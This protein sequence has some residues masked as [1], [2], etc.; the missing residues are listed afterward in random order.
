MDTVINN[1]IT[2]ALEVQKNSYSPYSNFCVGAALLCQNG[3]V[4]TGCNIESVSFTP[5]ICAERTAIAKAVSENVRDFKM[6][7]IVGKKRNGRKED[8]D[9]ISPC[10]VC[11]QM[12]AEFCDKDFKVIL[13][14][15]VDDYK[16]YTLEQ[17]LPCS[18]SK[19][20]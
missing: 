6:I 17:L 14:K 19:I 1:L 4:F 20:E 18:F 13:A 9:Y 3:K 11:R 10:G 7:A 5:T 8:I 15:N 2:K 16:I 12:L